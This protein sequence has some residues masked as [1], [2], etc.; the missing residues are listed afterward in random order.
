MNWHARYGSD[1]QIEGGE[2]E[3]ALTAVADEAVPLLLQAITDSQSQVQDD[4]FA[5]YDHR[6]QRYHRG[7]P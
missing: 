3:G 2:H 1:P 6:R 5:M 4:G 7:G